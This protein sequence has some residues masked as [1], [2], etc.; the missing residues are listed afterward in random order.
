MCNRSAFGQEKSAQETTG[1]SMF[2]WGCLHGLRNSRTRRYGLG[3][4]FSSPYCLLYFYIPPRPNFPVKDLQTVVVVANDIR[5]EAQEEMEKTA[6]EN[7]SLK[8][9]L[10]QLQVELEKTAASSAKGEGDL[11]VMF[12]NLSWE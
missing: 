9:K 2:E 6:M 3:T 10:N 4:W 8:E 12:G 1:L 11:V 7:T 5:K